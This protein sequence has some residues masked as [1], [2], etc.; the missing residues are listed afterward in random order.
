M[1]LLP[2]TR[3]FVCFLQAW[4]LLVGL[5]FPEG[6]ANC[7][8]EGILEQCAESATLDDLL[9]LLHDTDGVD[10]EA[11]LLVRQLVT[12]SSV[13]VHIL[14]RTQ[15]VNLYY[16][17]RDTVCFAAIQSIPLAVRVVDDWW[18]GICLS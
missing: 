2:H 6:V 1:V 14:Y 13:C 9:R 12:K 11:P 8:G 18:S 4:E 17:Q 10:S 7:V 15:P 16:S 5:G 3:F